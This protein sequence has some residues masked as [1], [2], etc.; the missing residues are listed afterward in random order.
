MDGLPRAFLP[1]NDNVKSTF[2]HERLQNLEA[3]LATGACLVLE[4]NSNGQVL[5]N[6]RGGT[7]TSW[8]PKLPGLKDFSNL[9]AEVSPALAYIA[10]VLNEFEA[11]R[12]LLKNKTLENISELL[13]TTITELEQTRNQKNVARVLG[14]YLNPLHVKVNKKH[15]VSLSEPV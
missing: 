9:P 2:G 4:L 11:A 6:V 5:F 10:K 1:A 8:P 12:L 3:F 14:F 15:S 7:C 13:E